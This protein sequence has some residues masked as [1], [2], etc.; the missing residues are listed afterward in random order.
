MIGGATAIIGFGLQA[1]RAHLP[2]LRDYADNP[3]A[4]IV[5]PS[6]VRQDRARQLCPDSRIFES[7][8]VLLR[9]ERPSIWII[10][11]PPHARRAAIQQALGAEARA[12]VCEKPLCLSATELRALRATHGTERIHMC[13][14]WRHSELFGAAR[15]QLCAG[16]IGRVQLV[17]FSTRR[18]RPAQGTVGW[19]SG[20][21]TRP[22]LAGG[23]ILMDHGYHSLYLARWLL[24]AEPSFDRIARFHRTPAGIEDECLVN[25]HC[26]EVAVTLDLS[27][28]A[29]ERTS[30]VEFCGET[31][32]MVLGEVRLE[33]TDRRGTRRTVATGPATSA[34]G[35]H[36]QWYRELYRQIG[37]SKDPGGDFEEADSTMTALF[38]TYAAV[39]EARLDYPVTDTRSLD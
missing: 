3:I 38:A 7:I 39:N 6:P 19:T 31:G 2:T 17:H 12:V 33:H 21:R 10:T 4:A 28:R 25:Y 1:E 5:D 20:W 16:S 34:D 14:N 8:D 29:A 13:H 9:H 30:S 27:W 32:R 26:G 22:E 35:V 24:H 15:A 11:T 23:G 18:T 36:Q 37:A